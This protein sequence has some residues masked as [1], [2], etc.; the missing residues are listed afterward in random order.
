M[1][2]FEFPHTRNYDGDLGY[3]IKK[4]DE[5]NA[6]YNNFFDYNSIKFH[7]PINWNIETIYTAFEIV[8][9]TQSE[10]FFIS[11]NAV[12]AGID[13]NNN[14]YWELITPFKTDMELSDV[15]SNP[16][17]NKAVTAAINSILQTDTT[18]A[19]KIDAEIERSKAVDNAMDIRISANTSAITEEAST[20]ASADNLLSTR[21]SE[22]TSLPEGS[23]SGDAELAD[24]RVGANGITYD[25]AGDAVRG[26]YNT[27]LSFIGTKE[28]LIVPNSAKYVLEFKTSNHTVKINNSY[29]YLLNNTRLS[30]AETTID[31]YPSTPLALTTCFIVYDTSDSTIKA[32]YAYA[33]TN[34]FNKAT[35]YI[36]AYFNISNIA[37]GAIRTIAPYI[38]DD[39]YFGNL[40]RRISN[41]PDKIKV[42]TYNVGYYTYGDSTAEYTDDDVLEKCRPFFSQYNVD[43]LGLQEQRVDLHGNT[44]KA[45]IYDYLYKNSYGYNRWAWL[46]TNH[47]ITYSNYYAFTAVIPGDGRP[48]IVN[49][50]MVGDKEVYVV[51]VHFALNPTDRAT[52]YTEL[53]SR[54]SGQEYVIVLGDFNAGVGGGD[55]QT[56]FNT[57]IS[58]G[59]KAAN[60]GYLGLMETTHAH[61]KIDNIFVSSN[62]MIENSF[63][64][65]VY[66]E[67]NSDHL[68]LIAE[69]VLL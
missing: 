5:L 15:S 18:L 67:M 65:D 44:S 6:R 53:L 69:L 33:T 51:T 17:A 46:F 34:G 32:V 31:Y 7:D 40:S 66:D 23:T 28:A 64:P 14:D 27:L 61:E 20:R 41:N 22:I 57:M 54:I 16:I 8:Y 68:P 21:I 19:G 37:N 26:Q 35:Q 36:L 29:L 58:A 24:I 43:I 55:P 56:E 12:P 4:L 9:D 47:E 49:K 39:I 25:S 3:I 42:C 10:A 2:Y 50:V 1:S 52:N 38:I 60:G 63:V 59:Y 13:I 11:K 45:L 30:I 48:Y 62:I